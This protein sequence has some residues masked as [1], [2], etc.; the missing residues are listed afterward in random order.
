MTQ[1]D[2]K[3]LL[4]KIYGDY[5]DLSSEKNTITN[6]T[7]LAAEYEK[8]FVKM[9][10]DT[11]E[12]IAK[13]A[14]EVMKSE[15]MLVLDMVCGTGLVADGLIK[16][17]FKGKIHGI[18]G[19]EG[20]L[21]VAKE[22]NRYEKLTNMYINPDTR[23]DISDSTYDIVV[24]CGGFGQSHLEPVVLNELIRVIKSSGYIV[25]STRFNKQASDYQKRMDKVNEQLVKDEKLIEVKTFETNYF[26]MD[27]DNHEKPL[28]AKIFCFQ[29]I[30]Q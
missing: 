4:N 14:M 1:S 2:K 5:I 26:D 13:T 24:C 3:E 16:A 15:N 21:E 17:G 28:L 19:S 18:D 11:P 27:F 12:V 8:D 30:D 6:Y 22:K 23:L 10:Y 29:K 9:G 7:K 25:Y 20:M